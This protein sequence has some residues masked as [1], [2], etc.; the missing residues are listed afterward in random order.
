M[1]L[2]VLVLHIAVGFNQRIKSWQ[3]KALAKLSGFIIQSTKDKD[4]V[5][6]NLKHLLIY[7]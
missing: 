3:S 5:N 1:N 2:S 4:N 7:L 6:G